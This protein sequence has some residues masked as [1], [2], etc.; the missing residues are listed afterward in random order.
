M[1]IINLNFY[2]YFK[3]VSATSELTF[4]THE[5]L[6]LTFFQF[7]RTKISLPKLFEMRS[8]AHIPDEYLPLSKRVEKSSF[9][10]VIFS[11][12]NFRNFTTSSVA[13]CGSVPSLA[14]QF[15]HLNVTSLHKLFVS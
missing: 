10:T 12:I 13:V 4:L 14:N 3:I 15:K 11:E 2:A 8:F 9:F 5:K 1:K 6:L 7:L